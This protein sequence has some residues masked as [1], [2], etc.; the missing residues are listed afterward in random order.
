MRPYRL[1]QHV[2]EHEPGMPILLLR[3]RP[4]LTGSPLDGEVRASY[5]GLGADE[6]LA[7]PDEHDP[8]GAAQGRAL[9]RSAVSAL[10]AARAD[11]P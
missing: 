8:A 6:Y 5:L 1:V 11:I 2:R 4:L 10:L 3:S 7:L 9:L